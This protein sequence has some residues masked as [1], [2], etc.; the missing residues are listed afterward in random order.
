VSRYTNKGDFGGVTPQIGFQLVGDWKQANFMLRT[1]PQR[2]D[3]AVNLAMRDFSRKYVR[4]VKEKIANQGASL[5]WAPLSL[6][7]LEFKERW[8]DHNSIYQFFGILSQSIKA[9]RRGGS[10][11]A[12]IEKGV[13]NPQLDIIRGGPG[14]A[15]DEYAAVLERGSSK[16]NITARPLWGPSYTQIGGAKGLRNTVIAYI[17]LKFPNVNLKFGR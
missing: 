12:G 16:R 15:V 3:Q 10:W 1:F 13:Q 7:Y 2:V 4:K 9:Q 17:K 8:S 14:L 11:S 5:G 6:E